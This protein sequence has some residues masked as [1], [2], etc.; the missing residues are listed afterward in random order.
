MSGMGLSPERGRISGEVI[1]AIELPALLPNSNELLESVKLTVLAFKE[2][3][4]NNQNSGNQDTVKILVFSPEFKTVSFI[5]S[6]SELADGIRDSLAVKFRDHSLEVTI[7]P[8]SNL[9]PCQLAWTLGDLQL[10]KQPRRP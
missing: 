5:V 2:D 3:S 9:T 8:A 10:P 6:D 1:L 7:N 4:Q